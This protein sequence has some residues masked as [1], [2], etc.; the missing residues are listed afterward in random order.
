MKTISRFASILAAFTLLLS[1]G[2]VY[3]GTAPAP[4]DPSAVAL[5][6]KVLNSN[7]LSSPGL[8]KDFNATG[9]VH[10]YWAGKDVVDSA[11]IYALGSDKFRFDSTGSTNESSRVAGMHGQLQ[12]GQNVETVPATAF[13]I[14]VNP[15]LPVLELANAVGDNNTRIDYMQTGQATTAAI[16]LQRTHQDFPDFVSFRKVY[17][18][19]RASLTIVQTIET[20]A[21]STQD[22]ISRKYLYG[23]FNTVQGI[24]VPLAISEYVSGQNTWT[25]HLTNIAFNIGVSS[26]LFAF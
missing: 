14:T 2:S 22:Q 4:Q 5:I 10:H 7:G 15:I 25:L 19:D 21:F 20:V 24:T 6:Q 17:V 23:N 13:V 12:T 9:D 11:Q 18:I 26:D 3:A 16:A 8:L 1:S